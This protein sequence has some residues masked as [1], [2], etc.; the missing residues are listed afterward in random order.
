MSETDYS[1]RNGNGVPDVFEHR[2]PISEILQGDGSQ[3]PS[4]AHVA[5]DEAPTATIIIEIG[6][7]PPKRG[8]M[9]F[10][11]HDGRVCVERSGYSSLSEVIVKQIV[12]APSYWKPRKE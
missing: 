11:S 7:R 5:P 8:E 2:R 1:D 3:S 9:Y 12:A 4:P 6:K 10:N